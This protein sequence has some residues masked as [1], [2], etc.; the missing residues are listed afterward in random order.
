[1]A[2]EQGRYRKW[3]VRYGIYLGA[4][5]ATQHGSTTLEAIRTEMAD[6]GLL[7]GFDR[8]GDVWLLDVY[9]LGP[10]DV[11][12]KRTGT[13]T[14]LVL[15]PSAVEAGFVESNK[16]PGPPPPKFDS[17]PMEAPAVRA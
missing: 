13:N 4:Q 15:L 14:A 1:M 5:L 9:R 6:D 8:H 17:P 2:I 16:H 10:F 12:A 3:L 7:D 11:D